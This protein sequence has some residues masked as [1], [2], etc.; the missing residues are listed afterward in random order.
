[1][2]DSVDSF[3]L[4]VL[5]LIITLGNEKPWENLR[6]GI[7]CFNLKFRKINLAEVQE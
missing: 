6:G 7:I 1:M 5:V 3:E 4:Q 2:V